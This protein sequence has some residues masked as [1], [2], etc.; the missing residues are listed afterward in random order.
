V[1]L[2]HDAA[3]CCLPETTIAR[4]LDGVAQWGAATA[5]IPAFDALVCSDGESFG[6]PVS[7]ENVWSVQTPQGFR[8][9]DLRQA[10]RQAKAENVQALDDASLVR[11]NR[12]V[13]LVMGDRLNVKVTTQED[14]DFVEHLMAKGVV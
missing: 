11:R 10:H 9:G 7:R 2:V 14:L 12:P 4:V 6:E 8:L 1:V 5:A 13:R 3:R